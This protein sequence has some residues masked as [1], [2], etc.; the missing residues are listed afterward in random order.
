MKI[1]IE[2]KW[3]SA[4]LLPVKKEFETAKTSLAA[5]RQYQAIGLQNI[6]LAELRVGEVIRL[7]EGALRYLA[8]KERTPE[9]N[10]Q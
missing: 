9:R 5:L 10:A 6:R 8:A 3:P 1:R 4:D 7:S 2:G